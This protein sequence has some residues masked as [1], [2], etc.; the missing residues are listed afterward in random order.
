MASNIS[1]VIVKTSARLHLGFIDLHGGMGRRYGSLGVSI[2]KPRCILEIQ[3]SNRGIS[4][5]DEGEHRIR[6][7]VKVFVDNLKYIGG[8]EVTAK[9][10]IPEHVG[11]GSGTQLAL[12]IGAA[13]ATLMDRPVNSRELSRISNRGAVSGIGTAV[14]AQ[15]GF[16][17][18]GGHSSTERGAGQK[19]IASHTIPPTI[20]HHDVPKDWTFVVAVPNIQ[21]GLSGV[22]EEKAFD[23]LP[24]AE[25]EHAHIISRLVLMQLL[26]AIVEDDIVLFGEALTRIQ[27]LVGDAFS[28]I[29]GGRFANPKVDACINAMLKA[30]AYGAG[31]SSWGPSCY[32][33][34]RETDQ[35]D[36][37]Q[38]AATKTLGA[39]GGYTFVTQANNRGAQI[40]KVS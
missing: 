18:D 17:I 2:D 14:F 24:A 36:S 4:V 9:E 29:Q 20:V 8:L 34:V 32:G 11:L 28:G 26:P 15:G 13:I 6:R 10:V 27:T 16:V 23:Q 7:L 31:Q 1:K 25:P 30:G 21:H 33:L 37:V 38:E 3:R 40:T 19:Q 12:A 39:K 22:T 5:A 35:I